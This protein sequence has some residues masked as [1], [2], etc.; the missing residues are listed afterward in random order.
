MED[1]YAQR[2]GLVHIR[3]FMFKISMHIAKIRICPFDLYPMSEVVL[4]GP[5][6]YVLRKK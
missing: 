2:W 1:W 3:I 4:T 5:T 6:T